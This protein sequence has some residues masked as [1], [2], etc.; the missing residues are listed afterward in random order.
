MKELECAR[1]AKRYSRRR[2]TTGGGVRRERSGSHVY[3]WACG[4]RADEPR[5]VYEGFSYWFFI[6]PD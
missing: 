5:E 3:V 4:A 1:T 6:F 2:R